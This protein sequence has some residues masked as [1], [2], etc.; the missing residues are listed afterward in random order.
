MAIIIVLLHIGTFLVRNYPFR[1]GYLAVDVFFILSG[2]LL[3]KTY[4]KLILQKYM[5]PI[6][7]LL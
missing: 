7:H 5:Y 1:S 4:D 2:F 3:A 6:L